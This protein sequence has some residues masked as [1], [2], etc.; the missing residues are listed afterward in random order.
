MLY[1]CVLIERTTPECVPRRRGRNMAVTWN[2][3]CRYFVGVVL[4]VDGCWVFGGLCDFHVV[5]AVCSFPGGGAGGFLRGGEIY[6]V[7]VL[8]FWFD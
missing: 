8:Y 3:L 5:G 4:I 6:L 2:K 1:D 7:G